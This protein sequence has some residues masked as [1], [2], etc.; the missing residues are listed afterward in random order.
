MIPPNSVPIVEYLG[1]YGDVLHR[2]SLDLKNE[3]WWPQ[4]E[5]ISVRWERKEIFATLPDHVWG[6][7]RSTSAFPEPPSVAR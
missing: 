1:Q 5:S 2:L 7:K 3:D 4:C 6:G